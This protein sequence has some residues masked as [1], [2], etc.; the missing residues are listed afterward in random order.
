MPISVESSTEEFQN[1]RIRGQT[2]SRLSLSKHLI[3]IAT[4]TQ[5]IDIDK[6]RWLAEI[7]QAS[8]A[9]QA[10]ASFAASLVRMQPN[11]PVVAEKGEVKDR[12]GDVQ[13]TYA[14]WE[15]INE[16][17][18]PILAKYGF[19]LTFKTGIE[20]RQVMVTG[21]L[22]HKAGHR[23]ETTMILPIDFSGA[24]NGVQAI[25][26]STSYGKRYTAIALLNRKHPVSAAATWE[27]A[28]ADPIRR[29][30]GW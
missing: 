14:L 3:S 9:R 4:S 8:E 28:S 30:A 23:E 16:T 25:G 18:R 6:L 24:K 21:V 22:S 1:A 15:D 19:A 13:Y 11:L 5:K 12:N 20:G 7:Q 10:R 17:V 26:S 29:P 27:P 2:R